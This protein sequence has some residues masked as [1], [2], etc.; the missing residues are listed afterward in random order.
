MTLSSV[1]R[2]VGRHTLRR[3]WPQQ[4]HFGMAVHRSS[5]SDDICIR[6]PT[7]EGGAKLQSSL[8]WCS[9]GPGLKSLRYLCELLIRDLNQTICD[10]KFSTYGLYKSVETTQ[11]HDDALYDEDDCKET[12]AETGK[13]TH[14]SCISTLP[15]P[16]STS[17]MSSGGTSSVWGKFTM[18]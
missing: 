2:E 7:L 8:S 4:P 16:L 1:G 14:Y 13:I 10:S 3:A 15:W 17:V 9:L 5:K 11:S 6:M 12:Q 18:S